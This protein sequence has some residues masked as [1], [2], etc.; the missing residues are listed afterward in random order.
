MQRQGVPK[1]IAKDTGKIYARN[2]K[3]YGSVIG[4][5]RTVKMSRKEAND[6]TKME[7]DDDL[8]ADSSTSTTSICYTTC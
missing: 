3:D 5:F 4:L 1:H 6:K 8:K 7:V 2:L